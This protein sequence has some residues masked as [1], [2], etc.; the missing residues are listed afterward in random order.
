MKMPAPAVYLDNVATTPVLPEVR[1]A[2]APFLDAA[3]FGNP[4]SPHQ[5]GRAARAAVEQARRQVASRPDS[6]PSTGSAA[7]RTR[8]SRA[9]SRI[10]APSATGSSS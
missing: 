7:S 3:A 1:D 5:Y 2:M 6:R 8:G 4:S 9:S 10:S